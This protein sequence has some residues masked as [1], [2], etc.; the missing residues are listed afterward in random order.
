[1]LGSAL[2]IAC[3]FINCLSD[4]IVTSIVSVATGSS[5]S[6]IAT[7][8]IALLGIG[9]AIGIDEAVVAGAIISGGKGTAEAKIKA[10][11]AAG[12]HVSENLGQVGELC[13]KVFR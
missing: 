1:M 10:M 7:I 2:F 11:T 5:W 12:I 3:F 8:G 4:R 6:T 9:K 13:V